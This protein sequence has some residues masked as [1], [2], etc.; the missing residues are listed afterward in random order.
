MEVIIR[1]DADAC[2]GIA[3]KI[4]VKHIREKEKPVLGLATG[5]TPEKVYAKFCAMVQSGQ[6]SFKHCTTFNLDEYV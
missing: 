3:V 6:I 1:K 5:S 4:V 2:V